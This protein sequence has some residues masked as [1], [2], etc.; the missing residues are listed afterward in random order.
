[1]KVLIL[2]GSGMLGHKLWQI[3]GQ[4]HETWITLRGGF[5]KIEK[6]QNENMKIRYDVDALNFDS[7]IRATAS[8]QP[9]ILIN[10]IG[11]IK[12]KPEAK[13]PLSAITINSQ[14]P[15][16]LSLICRTSNIRMIHISTDCVFSGVKGNYGENDP[17]DAEDLYGK[18]KF[19]GEVS[20]GHTVTLRTSI[21]GHE[22]K[23]YHG[24]I[25]WFLSQKGKKV[26]GFKK[27]IFS[28]LTTYDLGQIILNK[29]M[30]DSSISGVHQVSSNPIS[31]YDLLSIVKD[32]YNL[33]IEIAEE[34]DFVLD[35]SL[36]SERFRT[37]TN[38]NPDSWENMI[39]RMAEDYNRN[40]ELYL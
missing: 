12:Q 17:S 2:G 36:L 35:R 7:V 4:K 19:L 9:D 34:N 21:I 13:D 32:V 15:H 40:R 37:L 39:K 23:G 29:I 38:Y 30:P 22:L 20:Y 8:I 27:A 24:L 11:L 28:G 6:L 25:D 33:D 10:C 16:R 14:L 1:M 31:K 3:I 5:E 18:S 26:N